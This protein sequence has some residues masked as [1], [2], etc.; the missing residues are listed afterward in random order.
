MNR[1]QLA[2]ARTKEETLWRQ[3]QNL[4]LAFA[5][6]DKDWLAAAAEV[7][8]IEKAIDAEAKKVEASP[9]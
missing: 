1:A 7:R 6:A 9:A 2:E 5:T 4:A 8:Q 3:R